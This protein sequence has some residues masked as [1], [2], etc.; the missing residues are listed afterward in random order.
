MSR[1]RLSC[2]RSG[3]SGCKPRPP[4]LSPGPVQSKWRARWD[5]NP[6][7]QPPQGCALSGL[8][9]ER[10]RWAG[11]ARRFRVL[12]PKG[13]F[14]PP[15]PFRALRPERSA[16]AVPPLRHCWRP[17]HHES[18]LPWANL[19]PQHKMAG[20]PAGPSVLAAACRPP[21]AGRATVTRVPLPASLQMSIEPSCV[22]A[23]WRAM[24]RPSPAPPDSL[25]RALSTR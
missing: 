7:P 8:S 3:A 12:V 9:Y 6:R 21:C 10:A 15:R 25:V 24:A 4:R 18:S 14:E 23:M 20:Y 19:P 16:S 5:S 22:S 11:T 17:S 1:W 13:G 2:P